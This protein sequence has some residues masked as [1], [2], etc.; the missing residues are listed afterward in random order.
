MKFKTAIFIL[1]AISVVYS[2]EKRQ[3]TGYGVASKKALVS[4]KKQIRQQ[5]CCE[6]A[7]R[8]LLRRFGLYQNAIYLSGT[9]SH[10]KV[11]FDY[12]FQ[13]KL[14][15]LQSCRS[16]KNDFEECQADIY[17][18]NSIL[19]RS[20]GKEG[21]IDE[22]TY[23]VLSKG[24]A[25]LRSIAKNS[26]A[27]KQVTCI[28]ASKL[29][30]VSAMV[31]NVARSLYGTDEDIDFTL[32]SPQVWLDR[33]RSLKNQYEECECKIYLKERGLKQKVIDRL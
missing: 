23:S 18:P 22:N 21:W 11:Q 12:H 9:T 20:S 8:N 32:R 25:S 31:K 27:M 13:Q 6:H 16:T 15:Q 2:D 7:R 30:A 10:P 1:L 19:S 29:N 24:K 26:F 17:L 5:S 33:C 3:T 4:G 28:D 14:P